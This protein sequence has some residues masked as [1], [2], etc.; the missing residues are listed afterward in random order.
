MLLA[1]KAIIGRQKLADRWQA[2]PWTVESRMPEQDVYVIRNKEG[3]CKTVHR[4][5]LIDCTFSSE[6]ESDDEEELRPTVN[7]EAGLQVERRCSA[8]LRRKRYGDEPSTPVP[9]A[10]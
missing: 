2:T 6:G 9:S 8:R 1:N 4:N 7:E 10:Y 3:R 5:L